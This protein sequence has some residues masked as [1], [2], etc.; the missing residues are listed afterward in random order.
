[1]DIRC[2][3]MSGLDARAFVE[4]QVRQIR[5][6]LGKEKALIAV[7]GGVD[8]TVSGVLTHRAIGD[9]LLCVFIDDN[10]M[11]LGEPESVKKALSAPPLNLPVRVLDERTRFM[12]ALS[13]LTD[14]E[15][16]R[17]AFRETFYTTLAQAAEAEGCTHLVQGTI[18]A[19]I[20][21]TAGGVK[22]QHNVLEQVGIDPK[23][24]FGFEV[25]EPVASL[26]KHQV[27]EVARYLGMPIESSER[28]PFPG[29][30]LSIRVVGRITPQELEQLK[31]ATKITEEALRP[32]SP[33]QY[34][35]AIFS[36]Q[37]SKTP[38]S[39]LA[40][41]A[42]AL[43]KDP[44]QVSTRYLSEKATGIVGESRVY[45]LVAAVGAFDKGKNTVEMSFKTLERMRQQVMSKQPEIARVLYLLEGANNEGS[46]IA[47]RAIK[48]RDYLTAG[49]AEIPWAA[50]RLASERIFQSCRRVAQVY[51]DVTPKPPAT[52]EFE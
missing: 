47:L 45:G 9:N 40:E 30:G 21:E 22:T 15:E 1:M 50:L 14:A 13:G 43:E 35:A 37:T 29:P 28:Q 27:R 19:D 18:K 31:T 17:K 6:T 7:S 34:F 33:D 51:Y 26:Y 32:F 49:V 42:R 16:K 24:R 12:Q 20:V 44:S 48:T 5:E 10:F 4:Q 39:L 38:E 3:N 36:G 46:V 2:V 25:I 23:T 52:I 41:T 11:R 8:S